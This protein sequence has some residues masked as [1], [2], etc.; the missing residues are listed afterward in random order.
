MSTNCDYSGAKTGTVC[1]FGCVLIFLSPVHSQAIFLSDGLLV[2][3]DNNKCLYIYNTHR[4]K[5]SDNEISN[6]VDF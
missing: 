3:C 6:I 2:Y 5:F 4:E 1:T